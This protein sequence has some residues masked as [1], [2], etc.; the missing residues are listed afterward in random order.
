MLTSIDTQRQSS[1]CCEVTWCPDEAADPVL[2][3]DAETD[4]ITPAEA[5]KFALGILR[6]TDLYE[7]ILGGPA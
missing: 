3:I 1:L 5:R 7:R 2:A 6:A 4:G